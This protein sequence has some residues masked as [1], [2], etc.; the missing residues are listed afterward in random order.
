MGVDPG[1]ER[2]GYGVVDF[3]ADRFTAAGYGCIKTSPA[4]S[5]PARLHRIYEE[6]QKIIAVYRPERFAVEELFFNKNARTVMSVGQARGVAILAA[7]NAGVAVSEYT[8]LQVKQAVTGYGRA[9][10]DQVRYMVRAIL[11]LSTPPSPDDVADAL[12][13][14]ICDAL[15]SSGGHRNG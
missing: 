14:A 9:A 4:L 7:V 2:T 1:T 13:L 3:F 6:L 12:A 10:K 5:L 15:F 8:P 11:N